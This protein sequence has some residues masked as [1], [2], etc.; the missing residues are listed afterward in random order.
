MVGYIFGG[1]TGETQESLSRK[2]A[3]AMALAS[4]ASS[5]PKNVGEGLNALG[6]ALIYRALMN[7]ADKGEAAARTQARDEE[8][9][10]FGGGTTP[11][12]DALGGPKPTAGM[13]MP[14]AAGEVAATS[15]T[16]G[17][18]FSPFMATIKEGGVQNPYALA[19]IAATGRA[20]S[21]WSAENANRTW[22]DPSES[23]QPGKAGG[24]MSWRGPRYQALAATGDLSPQGQ[25]KFFLQE[26]PE[27]IQKLNSAKSVE[28][29]Q[30]FMNDAW[31]FAGYDRPGGESSRRLSFAKGY[32]PSF[33]GGNTEVASLDPSAGMSAANAI[34]AAAKPSGYIDPQVSV[35]ADKPPQVPQPEF[36]MGRFGPNINLAEM[37]PTRADIAPQIQTQT[38]S[39]GAP[40]TPAAALAAEAPPAP[41][42]TVY[43]ALRGVG[44]QDAPAPKAP[45]QVAQALMD[46]DYYPAAPSA[47][48]QSGPSTQQLLAVLNNPYSS[49]GSKAYAQSLLEQRQKQSDPASQLDQEY[50]RA[51]LEALKAKPTK[52]WNKLD[53]NTL[54][55]DDG[56][57]KSARSDGGKGPFRFTGT[58]VEA[59]SLNGLMDANRLTEEQAQQLGAGKT[60]TGPNGETLFLTPQGVFGLSADGTVSPMSGPQPKQQP[61]EP[62]SAAGVDIFGGDAPAVPTPPAPS[63]SLQPDPQRPGIIPL[64]GPKPQNN[65]IPAEMGARIGMGDAFLET[66]PSIRKK[67]ARGDASGPIDG[68]KLMLGIG[69]PAELWRN[70]ESGKEALI[71]NMTGAGMA[72]SEAENQAARYQISPT[73]SAETMIKKLDGLE[74]DLRATRKGAIDAK[75]GKLGDAPEPKTPVA[76]TLSA[77]REAIAR[78]APRDAVIKRLRENGVN[79]EGL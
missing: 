21:G 11:P 18:T 78:G 12:A 79:P 49:E 46:K 29:A 9:A 2:R 76:N 1:N 63:S 71:R 20:E 58:T 4:K 39:L 75:S 72:Q 56:D 34:D 68:A 13:P 35:Q 40:V 15:P 19:A 3:V 67:I 7:D 5:A 43:G 55:S 77:A 51:Q 27:L 48:G 17:D 47:P 64:T 74:R 73:D 45:T 30:Q 50:K 26:S 42:E 59:Q 52:K 53:D 8:A 14:E 33:Q 65:Q 24:I 10:L 6:N 54:Y 22:D 37:P 23:G 69:D 28:E 16:T 41:Q 25:A 70:I 66:L 36:D 62:Q 44:A 38:A 57:F 32:L 31:K 61:A 60:V